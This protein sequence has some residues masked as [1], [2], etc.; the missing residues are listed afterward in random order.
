MPTEIRNPTIAGLNL[1]RPKT[2]SNQVGLSPKAQTLYGWFAG[3]IAFT[4]PWSDMVELPY[5]V[6]FTRP[7]VILAVISWLLSWRSGNAV[8]PANLPIYAM[9]F[10]VLLVPFHFLFADDPERTGRRLLSYIG[11]F[12]MTF[13]IYQAI[14][15]WEMYTLLLRS[16]IAGCCIPLGGLAWNFMNGVVQ[17]DGRY[18]AAGFDPNDL[19]GQLALSIPT[20]AYL[21]INLPKRGIWFWMYL[22]LAVAGILLTASRSGLL[23]LL[24]ACIYP[25][26]GLIRR[27][28]NNKIGI[29]GSL[30]CAGLGVYSLSSNISFHRLGTFGDEISRGD[31]NGRGTVWNNG[32]ELFW[33][34]PVFG[35]GAGSF[36]GT[37]GG[38]IRMAAHNTYLEILV[39]HGAIGLTVFLMILVGLILRIRRYPLDER[40]LWWVTLGCWMILVTTLSWE[41]REITWLLW[42]LC[43]SFV[44]RVQ[45][46]GMSR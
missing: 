32:M 37:V 5:S 15:T 29:L 9:S 10:L 1:F 23:I 26:L 2:L 20:A 25:L 39:E 40:L 30:V 27:T 11:L 31:M 18:T 34:N 14:R 21:A 46:Q 3:L 35:I 7:M 24:L 42:G 16:F 4:V 44:A 41:N 12:L 28:K 45:Q 36:S 22:P 19:A 13:F 17:G 43:I 33:E 6:Q 38:G 8:R